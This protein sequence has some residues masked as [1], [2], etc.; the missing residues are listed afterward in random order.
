M[1]RTDAIRALL[2]ETETAHGA[3]ETTE[4]HGVYDEA[5]P[6]W[7]ARYA[8]E[9]GLGDLIG[10]PVQDDALANLLSRT[11]DDFKDAKPTPTQPWA[12]YTAQR[13]AE[14]L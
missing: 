7:Y 3:Y 9:H 11:F 1:E 6:S 4:L 14:E 13:I 10:H 12:M 5:W 8:V 2:D